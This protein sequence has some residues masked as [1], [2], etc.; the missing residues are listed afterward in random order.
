M[1][2]DDDDDDDAIASY[3]V[4]VSFTK[5]RS[6]MTTF[7]EPKTIVS[8]MKSLSSFDPLK[9]YLTDLKIKILR[10]FLV[11]TVYNLQG[12]YYPVHLLVIPM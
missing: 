5:W 2:Y 1:L 12:V 7:R 3:I 9:K 4:V 6:F 11:F 8:M 10:N